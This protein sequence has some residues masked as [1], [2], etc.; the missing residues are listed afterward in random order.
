MGLMAKIDHPV[1]DAL[2]LR[3]REAGNKTLKD[4]DHEAGRAVLD[5]SSSGTIQTTVQ[6]LGSS[7]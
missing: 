3:F 5:D 1:E 7:R 6:P 4:P 2:L